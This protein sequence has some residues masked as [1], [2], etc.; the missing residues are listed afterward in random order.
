MILL[1]A[2]DLIAGQVVR[3]RRGERS[4]MDVYSTDP[5]A[6]AGDFARRGAAWIHVVDLSATFEED[7]DARA[8]NA[9][10][11]RGICQ[12]PG[13]SVDTGGGVRDLAAIERLADAGAKRIAIGTALVRDPEFA[14]RAAAEFGELVVADVAARDGQVRVNGWREGEGVLADE[15]VARLAGAMACRRASTW[16]RIA[17]SLRWRA[18]PWSRPAALPRLMTC[19]C[20]RQRETTSSREPSQVARSM[21]AT[22]RW[23]TPWPPHRDSR[24][25]GRFMPSNTY[26]SE[27]QA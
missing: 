2:I 23:K 13:I 26:A 24:V 27:R 22:S 17:T 4:Q 21:K 20:S 15:L 19:V 16:M 10:A 1:P 3:L 18:F 25:L 11:I 5:V 8:A 9:A 7:E 6:V 12:V 14:R